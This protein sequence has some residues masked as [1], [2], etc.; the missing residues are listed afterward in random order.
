MSE[1]SREQAGYPDLEELIG[2]IPDGEFDSIQQVEAIRT[3]SMVDDTTRR[4]KGRVSARMRAERNKADA[5]VASMQQTNPTDRPN[6][7][8][9]PNLASSAQGDEA[10]RKRNIQEL[11]RAK[12]ALASSSAHVI[13]AALSA[14][15]PTDL[16][17]AAVLA[18]DG[19]KPAVARL[20]SS[21]NI[22]L[23]MSLN[24]SQTANLMSALLTCNENQLQAILN[25]AK[26]PIAVKI[27][28]K[29]L[30]EDAKH[31]SITALEALW[32]RIFG[33]GILDINGQSANYQREQRNQPTTNNTTVVLPAQQGAPI[34]RMADGNIDPNRL[35]YEAALPDQPLSREAYLMIRERYVVGFDPADPNSRDRNSVSRIP[36][37]PVEEAEYIEDGQPDPDPTPS[38]I[39]LE[40]LL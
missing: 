13:A 36:S 25:N 39:K 9:S 18:Q 27:M 31:G 14:T 5:A 24:G 4:A 20:L 32:D 8:L 22:N 11:R 33:K 29:R 17:T 35:L 37:K 2:F 10:S 19:L 6:P 15:D 23:D 7:Y 21:L 12:D 1:N 26:V 16:P 3:E 38:D 30:I 28:A 34:K 40:D